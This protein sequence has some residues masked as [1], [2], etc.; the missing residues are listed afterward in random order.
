MFRD[1]WLPLLRARMT[2]GMPAV[3]ALVGLVTLAGCGA[4]GPGRAP[5]AGSVSVGGKPLE[6]GVVRFIPSGDTHG[7]VA[8][9]T[10]TDGQYALPEHEGPV[11]GTHR[12]EIEAIDHLNFALDDEAAYV[13]QVERKRRGM[14]R[15]PIPARYNRQS[16][17]SVVVISDEPQEFDFALQSSSKPGARQ[18]SSSR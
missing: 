8:V 16:T 7:P 5:V 15:N 12:V 13:Q 17:L 9:A 6:A 11:L 14:P 4:E 10:V 18:L 3:I 1:H 2:G